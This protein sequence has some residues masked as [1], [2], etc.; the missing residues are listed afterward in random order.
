M[1]PHMSSSEITELAEAMIL[2]QQTLSPALKDAVNTFTNSRYATLHSVMET[3]RSAL[4]THGVWLTQYPVAAETGQLG[5]VTKLVHAESGRRPAVRIL[6]LKSN[7][8]I[9]DRCTLRMRRSSMT[10]SVCST[11]VGTSGALP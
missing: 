11:R 3:C 1:E 10:R 7:E 6:E 2:V 4:L 5:L 9:P 8:R